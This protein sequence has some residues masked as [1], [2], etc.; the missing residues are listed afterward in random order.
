[1]L[2]FFVNMATNINI[3]F[4]NG[5]FPNVSTTGNWSD[6]GHYTQVIWKNTT[7]VGCGVA[8]S[9]QGEIW[10]CNYNPPGNYQGQNPLGSADN[11]RN[12]STNPNQQSNQT[13]SVS[14]NPQSNC[15]GQA[16]LQ[17]KTCQGDGLNSEEKKLHQLINQ[18]RIQNGLPPIPNSPSLNLV[19]NRHVRD[20]EENIGSL[21]HSWSD[22]PFDY[23]N[24]A[25]CMWK[26]P[27]RLGTPYQGYGYENAFG[28]SGGYRVDATSALQGWQNSSA[29][30][31]VILNQGMWNNLQWK[32]LGIGIY[33]GYAVLWFG[34]QPDPAN[35]TN[36][37]NNRHSSR[38]RQ[39][40]F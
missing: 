31:A 4:K 21:T 12:Y 29:H 22:C 9:N 19:A 11:P 20:L 24:K 23:N 1:L 34:E 15:Q 8:R 30:N 28:G 33:K 2:S 26:A 3:Y 40:E 10:V 39:N 16:I 27:Q 32:A 35:Y 17:A 13:T 36:R 37:S 18:Y 6:V 7:E 25:T 14:S 38:N 5:T